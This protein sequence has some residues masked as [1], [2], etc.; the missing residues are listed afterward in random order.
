ML[1]VLPAHDNGAEMKSMRTSLLLQ[2]SMEHLSL[3]RIY[4][5]FHKLHSLKQK[6]KAQLETRIVDNMKIKFIDFLS[7]KQIQQITINELTHCKTF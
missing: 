2:E 3:Y 6:A 4:C 1:K 5:A 7:H